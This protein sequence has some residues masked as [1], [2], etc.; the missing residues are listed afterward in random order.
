LS[1]SNTGTALTSGTAYFTYLGRLDADKVIKFIKFWVGTAGAGSQTAEVGLFSTPSAPCRA[2]QTLTKLEATGT[3]DSLT[4]TG[5]KGNTSAFTGTRAAGTHLWAG[6]RTAMA[7]TQPTIF[8]V[9]GDFGSGYVLRTASATAFTSG[10]TYTG[11]L[12]TAAT[13]WNGPNLIGS[14]D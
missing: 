4:T 13:G 9:W 11:A 2:G 5:V 12:V 8:G 10:T 6:V 3:V 7:T 1:S 14:L